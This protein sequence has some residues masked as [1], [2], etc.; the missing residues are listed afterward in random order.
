MELS[1]IKGIMTE[2]GYFIK[3]DEL[4]LEEE[5]FVIEINK[6]EVSES[7]PSQKLRICFNCGKTWRQRT[8]TR[9]KTCPSKHC[10]STYWET[11]KLNRPH[12]KIKDTVKEDVKGGLWDDCTES[13]KDDI[14]TKI[15]FT[16]EGT[17]DESINTIKKIDV[18]NSIDDDFKM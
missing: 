5:N 17:P 3:V 16:E 18:Q 13:K 15:E 7:D 12:F 8:L 14:S 2:K 6:K 10:H 4:S 11:P 9:P 1:N